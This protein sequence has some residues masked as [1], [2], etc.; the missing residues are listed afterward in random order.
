MTGREKR[1]LI[2][3]A[4]VVAATI[5]GMVYSSIQDGRQLRLEALDPLQDAR[6]ERQKRRTEECRAA[7][8]KLAQAMET[9]SDGAGTIP[10]P[11]SDP[12]VGTQKQEP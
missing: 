3:G 9:Y 10:V 1:L 11:R 6:I 12:A 4:A 7:M 2:V 8:I 5:A